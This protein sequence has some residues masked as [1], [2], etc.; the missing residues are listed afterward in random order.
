MSPVDGLS[1]E[2]GVSPP[3]AGAGLPSASAFAA[4]TSFVEGFEAAAELISAPLTWFG[5]QSGCAWS[6]SAA[7]PEIIGVAIEVPLVR[8]YSL[9]I[10]QV[11]HVLANVLPGASTETMCAP[12]AYT[13]GFWKPSWVVPW[14]DHEAIVSS[15][16]LAEPFS[17]TAPTVIT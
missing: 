8:M 12:G 11:G 1:N 5:V 17:S 9:S 16:G 6:K 3:S 15:S 7:S 14:L 2:F 4:S 10:R 13:S